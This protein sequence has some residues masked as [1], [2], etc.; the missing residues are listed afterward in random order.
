MEVSGDNGGVRGEMQPKTSAEA[1][2]VCMCCRQGPSWVA[3]EEGGGE[4]M[5]GSP[6]WPRCAVIVSMS[7]HSMWLTAPFCLEG[8]PCSGKQDGWG[9]LRHPG[10]GVRAREGCS[11][12]VPFAKVSRMECSHCRGATYLQLQQRKS[13]VGWNP[14]SPSHPCVQSSC[15]CPVSMLQKSH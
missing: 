8:S 9:L 11:S 10:G 14:C 13:L 1:P 3:T 12:K 2:A 7:S 15:L 5:L 6:E 4:V